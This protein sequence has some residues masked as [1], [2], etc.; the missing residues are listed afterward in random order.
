GFPSG[1]PHHLSEEAE[2]A[3]ARAIR[4]SQSN[5]KACAKLAVM[6]IVLATPLAGAALDGAQTAKFG[7]VVWASQPL[8]FFSRDFLSVHDLPW[9]DTPVRVDVAEHPRQ[10][11]RVP[12]QKGLIVR[13]LPQALMLTK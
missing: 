12:A 5:P 4:T 13:Q 2:N 3:R 10:G 1:S 7:P 11:A 9:Q 8:A 6:P